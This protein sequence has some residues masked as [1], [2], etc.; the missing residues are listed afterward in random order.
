MLGDEIVGAG[1]PRPG[2]VRDVFTHTLP[3]VLRA[4]GADPIAAERVSDDADA[5]ATVLDA[6]QERIVVTTGGT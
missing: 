6:A 3:T 2:Q 1:V 5:T 4:F